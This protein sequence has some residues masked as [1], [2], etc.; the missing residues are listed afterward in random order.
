MRQL[1]RAFISIALAT[2]A[3]AATPMSPKTSPGP[4]REKS[5]TKSAES[6][7]TAAAS[8]AATNV[9]KLKAPLSDKSKKDADAEFKKKLVEMMDKI[10][11]SV[12]IIRE[13]IV[14]NQ[15]AP[16][17]ADLYM[18]LG[19]LLMQKSTVHYYLQ[20]QNDH[21]TDTKISASSKFSPVVTTAQEAI[22]IYDQIMKE[23]P[24]FDKRDQVLYRLA[25]AQKSIDESAAFVKSSEQLI[26]DYPNTKE[27]IQARLLLGQFYFDQQAYKDSMEQLNV[28]KESTYP[29]ERD[30]AKYRIGLILI[31]QEKHADALKMFEAVATDDELKEDLNPAEIS[32]KTKVSKT[33]LKREALIDSVR[34]YTEVYK[35]SKTDAVAYYS[36]IAP[37]E[38][39]FQETIEKLAY[40]E[41]FLRRY[42]PAIK[43]LR[44]LSERIADPQK[45]VNIYQEV[46]VGI[47]VEE[48]I[49]VPLAEMS[50][51][52]NKF[53][54]WSS[55][56][57][58]S[59]QLQKETYTFFEKQIRELGTRSHDMAKVATDAEKKAHLYERARQYY[60]LYLGYFEKGPEAVKIATNLADVYYNQR[61]FFQ[62]GTYY[63][64]IFSNE[65]GQPKQKVELI[66]NAILSLQKPADYTYF[67]QVRAKGMMVKAIS[68]YMKLDPKKK[69]DPALNFAL[70]KAYFEQGYYGRAVKDLYGLMKRFPNSHEA[71]DSADLI[72]SYFN[73]RSDFKGL[74]S[75]SK[76]LMD[77][78]NPNKQLQAHLEDVH[79][80]AQLHRLDE[81]VK[82]AKDYDVA[83]QGRSYLATALSI[84]D[85]SLRSAALQ[86]ALGHSKEER[87][88]ETFLKT[89]Q[90]MAKVE[91][92]AKK[93]AEIWNSMGDETLAITRFYQAMDIYYHIAGDTTLEGPAR[94]AAYDKVVKIASMLHDPNR[95]ANLLN[96]P[97]ARNLPKETKDSM[98]QQMMSMLDSSIV[99]PEALQNYLL[100]SADDKRVMTMFKAQSKLAPNV[101]KT[102]QARVN[103]QCSGAA[104]A[105]ICKWIKWPLMA[106]RITAFQL[107]MTRVP[108]AMT[109]IDP[110]ATKMTGLLDATKAYEN[111]GEPQ[112]DV[113]ITLGN[114]QIYQAFAGFLQRAAAANKDVAQILEAKAQESLQ[115]AKTS[116]GQCGRVISAANLQSSRLAQLCNSGGGR[117]I[118]SIESTI[119]SGPATRLSPP[120]RDPRD[121]DITDMQKGIFAKRDDWK[122]YLSLGESYLNHRDFYHAAATG[123]MARSAFPQSEEEFNAITGCAL[124][125][126]GL[127]DEAR[128]VLNKASD[129]NG[130]K[131]ACLAQVK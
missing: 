22:A 74:A 81:Q 125:G 15:S 18:Q 107:E 36:K 108:A 94:N 48:R 44:V 101:R 88:I 68:S 84:N 83:S 78:H 20:M 4:I 2:P 79:S 104:N 128:Y 38:A 10:D 23:F 46:L 39:L 124:A 1:S 129:V 95:L 34:A 122:S 111:S 32:L 29:Y 42:E 115:A 19:D 82:Q 55:H 112:V 25:V 93:R 75:W 126:A 96:Q 97:M 114:A 90:A 130:H 43:L 31:Q 113:L 50:F 51:V 33:N 91:K 8:A 27:T 37:T 62:S 98:D 86:Q 87:D 28:V 110:S 56:Y 57:S 73:T 7:A 16:F 119:E 121:Q 63:L 120:N 85:S 118:A 67:E 35:D 131:T 11:K 127:K 100:H 105:P 123:M 24:K 54:D 47:P 41:I 64:R 30:A 76:K 61:N 49:D 21:R 80:K 52:L 77:L 106:S 66:Q 59:P 58:L 17:L 5:A 53:S 99:L 40:R 9:A 60:E 3:F 71:V 116:Q 92:D 72:L 14:Q 109:A 65:F 12:K 6:A 117:G 45:I 13:Q 26:K 103:S 102:L 70:C 69:D 89:A